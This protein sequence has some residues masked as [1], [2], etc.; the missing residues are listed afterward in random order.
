MDQLPRAVAKTL[1][2][3]VRGV[4]EQS[5]QSQGLN[6]Q[7]SSAQPNAGLYDSCGSLPTHDVLWFCLTAHIHDHF[8]QGEKH[9]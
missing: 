9:S 7:R 8:L 1:S 4:S 5:S 3:G 6:F 2:A